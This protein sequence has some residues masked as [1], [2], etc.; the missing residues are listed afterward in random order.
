M[1]GFLSSL[2]AR[3]QRQPQ[4]FRRW[5]ADAAS[6]A[7]G[8]FVGVVAAVALAPAADAAGGAKDPEHYDWSFN[9]V[10]GTYDTASLQRGYQV[11]KQVCAACHSMDYVA[12]RHLGERGGP[13]YD[14]DYPN[15][16]DNPVVQAV[17]RQFGEDLRPV[18]VL[19]EFGDEAERAPEAADNI[20]GPFKNEAQARAINGGAYPPDFSVIVKARHY[21]ADYIRSLLMGYDYEVP[22]ALEVPFGQWYNPYYPGDVSGSW[23]GD[24]SKVP[25]GGF[26]AMAPVLFDGLLEYTDGTEASVEQMATDVA[27]F[28]NWAAYPELEERKQLG[29]SV[30]IYL[31]ILAGLL[32]VSYHQIWKNVKK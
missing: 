13:F 16:N 32:W 20:P 25:Y 9:G 19:D 2:L 4:R 12:F 3:A 15:P 6:L 27:A 8:C 1:T 18:L 31:V 11:Y 10:F 28:L 17:A 22:A 26:I 30:M 7:A 21:G 14:P 24:P 5:L 29:L 23:N